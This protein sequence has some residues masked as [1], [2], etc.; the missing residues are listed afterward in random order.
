MKPIPPGTFG[1]GFA[2]N[3][4]RRAL[5]AGGGAAGADG[6]AR[7]LRRRRRRRSPRPPPAAPTTAA[8]ETTAGVD[9]DRGVRDHDGRVDGDHH[10]RRH[11]D[12][13]QGQH[14]R[15]RRTVETITLGLQSLQEQYVDPHFGVGGLIFPL[16]WAISD[17]LY[18]LDQDAQYV[19]GLA[20]EL[21]DQRRQADVDVHAAR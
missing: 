3:V 6:A 8:P 18:Q 9:D 1:F 2:G 5:L 16:Q 13:E 11:R 17:T 14:G 12:D 21:R 10:E 7:R 4:S 20:T 19:P 15:P